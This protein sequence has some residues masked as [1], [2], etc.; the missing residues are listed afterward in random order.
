MKFEGSVCFVLVSLLVGGFCLSPVECQAQNNR[1]TQRSFVSSPEVRGMGDA[2][3]ALPGMEQGF[4]YN[5]A[6]LPDVSSHFTIFG[7][8][9][10]STASLDDQISFINERVQP[11]VESSVDLSPSAFA[12]FHRKATALAGR[13]GRGM[14]TLLLPSFV[15]SGEAFGVGGGLFAKTAL[16]YRIETPSAGG[17][18][19]WLLSRTD[20]MALAS[21]GLDLEVLG[22]S[23]VS[24]GLTGT[25]TRRRLA[26]KQK[27][28]D[29]LRPDEAAVFLDGGVF[30][31]DV[32]GSYE[33]GWWDPLPGTLR[34]G[35]AVYDVLQTDY[36]YSSGGAGRMPFLTEVVGTSADSTT[37]PSDMEIDRARALF[38]L[39]SSYR[40][41]VGYEVSPVD[42]IEDLG[43]ALDYQGYGRAAQTPFARIHAGLRA[44]VVDGVH[45]RGG[46]N[47]GYPSGGLGVEIGAL[48]LDYAL[49]G[50]VEGRKA[51]Q[52][53]VYVH[54]ARI[55]FRLK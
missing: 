35:G 36:A 3:V 25:Q 39:T 43:I 53:G 24:L 44:E 22:L 21:A 20:V 15:Y 7:V 19:V 37:G 28:I 52:L 18:S 41:G 2:G 48:Y 46:I 16:N 6:H 8:Q 11:A 5:P 31:L 29:R 54:T 1:F 17:P 30:Q 49:G 4:F 45:V 47:S 38:A 27:P 9:G 14:G 12:D 51:G 33:P 13:P 23:G 32:G 40:V 42:F 26:F 34:F 55:L 50:V 10:A